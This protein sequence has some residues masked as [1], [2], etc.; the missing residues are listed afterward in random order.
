M[1]VRRRGQGTTARARARPL[2][3]PLSTAIACEAVAAVGQPAWAV[4][5]GTDGVIGF[6]TGCFHPALA[7][8][9]TS[10]LVPSMARTARR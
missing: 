9:R 2:H 1:L 4:F 6:S 10:T 5:P 8:E 3:A 7:G